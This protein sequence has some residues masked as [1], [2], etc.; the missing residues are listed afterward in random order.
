MVLKKMMKTLKLN[1]WEFLRA[2]HIPNARVKL[3]LANSYNQ[4]IG[5][6]YVANMKAGHVSELQDQAYVRVYPANSEFILSKAFKG[7]KQVKK[8]CSS[9]NINDS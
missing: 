4:H 6:P 1:T 2:F 8:L 9:L 3:H 7:T 5:E